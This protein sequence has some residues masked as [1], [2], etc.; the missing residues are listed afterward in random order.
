MDKP[1]AAYTVVFQNAQGGLEAGLLAKTPRCAVRS[2][3]PF[4]GRQ[5]VGLATVQIISVEA[6]LISGMA[7]VLREI[8][9]NAKPVVLAAEPAREQ[10]NG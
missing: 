3:S 7:F 6:E 8:G 4:E 1:A 2:V 9:P 10:G 5:V